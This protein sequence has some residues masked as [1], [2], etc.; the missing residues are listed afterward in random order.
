MCTKSCY[1]NIRDYENE[2]FQ[3]LSSARVRM[4]QRYFGGKTR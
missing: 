2:I 1:A 3:Y 4:N